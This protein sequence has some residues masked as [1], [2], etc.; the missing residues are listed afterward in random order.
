MV[1]H[2]CLTS[3]LISTFLTSITQTWSTSSWIWRTIS[4]WIGFGG[5]SWQQCI[6]RS[7]G[8]PFLPQTCYSFVSF[9]NYAKRIWMPLDI[10]LTARNGPFCNQQQ[11]TGCA[12][13]QA[14]NTRRGAAF[15][16]AGIAKLA[17]DRLA[18]Y[19]GK[20]VPKLYR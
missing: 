2:V 20:L 7:L 14:L 17:G 8:H 10:L 5:C 13:L 3:H 4:R 18:P 15:G 19:V 9:I 12:N 16:V 1:S 6:L 11:A